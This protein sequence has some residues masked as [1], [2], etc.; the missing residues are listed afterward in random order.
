MLSGHACGGTIRGPC[1]RFWLSIIER[2]LIVF[3]DM[4]GSQEPTE[5]VGIWMTDMVQCYAVEFGLCSS[6]LL[7]RI[8]ASACSYVFVRKKRENVEWTVYHPR[9][10]VVVTQRYNRGY[11]LRWR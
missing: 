6:S 8:S 7:H 1:V 10:N 11:T 2:S 4:N 9:R 5:V 3:R